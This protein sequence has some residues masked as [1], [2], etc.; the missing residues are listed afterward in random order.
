MN[1]YSRTV[2]YRMSPN[3]TRMLSRS[4]LAVYV[5]NTTVIAIKE[6][7]M[8][9]SVRAYIYQFDPLLLLHKTFTEMLTDMGAVN[10]YLYTYP[11]KM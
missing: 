10:M 4:E 3:T 8:L 2:D 6:T 9:A 1:I 7:S 5:H 11:V